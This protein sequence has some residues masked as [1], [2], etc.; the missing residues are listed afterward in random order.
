MN[1]AG[2]VFRPPPRGGRVRPFRSGARAS[3]ALYEGAA[4]RRRALHLGRA[5][6]LALD[7]RG[8][9]RMAGLG[10]G[11]GSGTGAGS[12]CRRR[13]RRGARLVRSSRR[14]I[15]GAGR[16]RAVRIEPKAWTPPGQPWR[17]ACELRLLIARARGRHQPALLHSRGPASARPGFSSSRAEACSADSES[18]CRASARGSFPTDV[19]ASRA[20]RGSSS[21]GTSPARTAAIGVSPAPEVS[22]DRSCIAS[23]RLARRFRA[24]LE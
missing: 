10:A 23:V 12:P 14:A 15:R 16:G 19:L 7:R 6:A 21:S 4:R 22:P 17:A 3:G 24:R 5:A 13:L 18:S 8:R 1:T 2:K 11:V 9:V 20:L